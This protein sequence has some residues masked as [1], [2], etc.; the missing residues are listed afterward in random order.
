MNASTAPSTR[1]RRKPD[2]MSS[3][4]SRVYTTADV[5]T[6]RSTT[7]GPTM[8]TTV[9]NSR[10]RQRRNQPNPLSENLAA[11]HGPYWKGWVL[12][13]SI[14]NPSVAQRRWMIPTPVSL[15]FVAFV[16]AGSISAR[17]VDLSTMGY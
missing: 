5:D 16:N 17:R 2:A 13:S 11:G 3:R 7:G 6:Q 15:T 8:S 14:G 10:Q 1:R 4:I 12:R 9:I